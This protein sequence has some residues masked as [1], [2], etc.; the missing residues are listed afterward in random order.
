MISIALAFA[1]ITCCLCLVG[2][3]KDDRNNDSDICTITGCTNDEYKQDLCK[4][5]YNNKDDASTEYETASP[6]VC[7]EYQT[8]SQGR[9]II[10]KHYDPD[11]TL[12]HYETY[13]YD[14]NGNRTMTE[15]Y[16]RKGK[17]IELKLS[18][19]DADNNEIKLQILDGNYKTVSIIERKFSNGIIT[20]EIV[21]SYSK[22]IIRTKT[23]TTYNEDGETVDQTTTKYDSEGNER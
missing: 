9:N 4:E 21:S 17:L 2:C 16:D 11:G 8:D 18:E 23:T 6:T 7:N 14:E 12:S 10:R 13:E 20:E 22:G 3:D 19:F 15:T 5:H 1:I